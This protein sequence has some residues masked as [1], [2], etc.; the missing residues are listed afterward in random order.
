RSQLFGSSEHLRTKLLLKLIKG[1]KEWHETVKK[2]KD[3]INKLQGDTQD[4]L[5]ALRSKMRLKS[6]EE[7][8]ALIGSDDT[9]LKSY[10]DMRDF[11]EM[12]Q[13]FHISKQTISITSKVVAQGKKQVF[14]VNIKA[15]YHPRA[16]SFI[17]DK[18][19]E[20]NLAKAE[21]KTTFSTP[22]QIELTLSYS[23][24]E[25]GMAKK[26]ADI[27]E[28]ITQDL[29]NIIY[30]EPKTQ[31]KGTTRF[32]TMKATNTKGILIAV[33]ENLE[34]LDIDILDINIKGINGKG[35]IELL[36]YIPENITT[37][38]IEQVLMNKKTTLSKMILNLDMIG[39]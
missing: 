36:T 22:P 21:M 17:L 25:K 4:L 5:G 6:T 12:E 24:N 11:A 8:L 26:I 3:I 33:V 35:I 38:D 29:Q 14:Q 37:G 2:G 15:P 28:Q 39:D 20:Y 7:L 16:L 19:R 27:F 23:L 34:K 32:I 31:K 13:L 9:G 18:F 1:S 30:L 10:L